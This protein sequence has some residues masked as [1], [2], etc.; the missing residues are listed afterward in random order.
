MTVFTVYSVLYPHKVIEDLLEFKLTEVSM[1]FRVMMLCLAVINFV[2]AFLLEVRERE[3]TILSLRSLIL[4]SLQAFLV[5]Y[6]IFIKV[7]E[8][9]RKITA[10]ETTFEKIYNQTKTTD[11]LPIPCHD[12]FV[13]KKPSSRSI[14]DRQ[15]TS[16][17]ESFKSSKMSTSPT[18]V[19]E[20]GLAHMT[21]G[22]EDI[23][24][25]DDK[26]RV[27]VQTSDHTNGNGSSASKSTT[28]A[29]ESGIGISSPNSIVLLSPGSPSLN[30][31]PDA[32]ADAGNRTTLGGETGHS[33][34]EELADL[35]G[36]VIHGSS[37]QQLSS[38]AKSSFITNSWKSCEDNLIS[39]TAA[40]T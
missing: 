39:G 15:F 13:S 8:W 35:N 4:L 17:S 27:E 37:T 38:S 25:E 9:L 33:K 10:S 22:I 21:M 6:F 1:R 36:E 12:S 34:V 16:M 5:D 26:L 28:S 23:V 7:K 40:P 18:K 30:A 19:I 14:L 31:S 29:P 11:W 24:T 3:D 2:L 32:A 20:N